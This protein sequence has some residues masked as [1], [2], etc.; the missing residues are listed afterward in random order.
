MTMNLA[1][2]TTCFHRVGVAF[3]YLISLSALAFFF[4]IQAVFAQVNFTAQA[5]ILPSQTEI[6]DHHN[7]GF[8]LQLGLS[9]G[10]PF[11][12]YTLNDP[13]RLVLDFSEVSWHELDR[14][15]LLAAIPVNTLRAGP[16]RH[17]WSRLVFEL[18][19]PLAVQTAFMQVDAN[20]QEARLMLKAAPVSEQLF[21]EV[22]GAPVSAHIE[23][24][25]NIEAPGE[26]IRRQRGD[27]RLV[28][29]L[30]P[31][32]GGV[33]P[34]A[35]REGLREADLMLDFARALR[36]EL[37]R[38]G[39]FDVVLTRTDDS[40]VSLE[41]RVTIART[42]RAD[43][44]ISLHADTVSEGRATGTTIYTLAKEATDEASALLA[45]RHDRED[46]L[47]GVDL[48]Y[49]DDQVAMVLMDLARRETA[50]RSTRLA[51][52]LVDM[53]GQDVGHLYK[54][55]HLEAGFS[56]LKAPDIPSVLVELGFMNNPADLDRIQSREWA[57]A[58]TGAIGNAIQVWALE[59]AAEAQLI[60]Q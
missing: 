16:L 14:D 53:I 5:R 3:L 19:I 17:G 27:R 29:V 57:R 50:P 26:M 25:R 10:V 20:S 7:G 59:D 15:A 42:S 40:F 11:Q 45:E 47:A 21:A 55:P 60:R 33:D 58:M 36:E 28:I 22:S 24:A 12:V 1:P 23:S 8:E 41:R 18:N 32:H 35:E 31:G 56:V 30:D 52:R 6:V 54:H 44:F 51:Q 38:A 9:R 2:R 48:S 49:H 34:G 4:V 43:L 13:M 46:L 37:V 39:G